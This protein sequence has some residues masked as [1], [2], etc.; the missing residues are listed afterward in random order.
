VARY[1]FSIAEL[2][3]LFDWPSLSTLLPSK[4]LATFASLLIFADCYLFCSYS[5]LTVKGRPV[6]KSL[7]C[8]LPGT[9][10]DATTRR[11]CFLSLPRDDYDPVRLDI[12]VASIFIFY[13][14]FVLGDIFSA[15]FVGALT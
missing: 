9:S 4:V 8:P 10:G 3:L 6:L 13:F 1:N 14:I 11:V 7:R 5:K 15:V 2:I 12:G